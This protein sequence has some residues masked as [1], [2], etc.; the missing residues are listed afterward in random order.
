MLFYFKVLWKEKIAI[1]VCMDE[2]KLATL[3]D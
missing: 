3:K 2:Q 1:E